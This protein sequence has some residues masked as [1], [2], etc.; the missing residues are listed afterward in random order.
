MRDGVC[1][2]TPTRVMSPEGVS[3]LLAALRSFLNHDARDS[4]AM[5]ASTFAHEPTKNQP[6]KCTQQSVFLM[7]LKKASRVNR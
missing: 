5:A 1:D 6:T 4:F 2:E 3:P 7:R